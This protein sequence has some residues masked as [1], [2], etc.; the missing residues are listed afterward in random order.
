D[1]VYKLRYLTGWQIR[2][3]L[4]CDYT[5]VFHRPEVWNR[6]VDYLGADHL[7]MTCCEMRRGPHLSRNSF[8]NFYKLPNKRRVLQSDVFRATQLIKGFTE[9]SFT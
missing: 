1:N 2:H 7:I 8:F 9:Q 5:I 6:Y 3:S 4:F